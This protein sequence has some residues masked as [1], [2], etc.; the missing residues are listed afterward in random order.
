MW[1][2]SYCYSQSKYELL[3]TGSQVILKHFVSLRHK[4]WCRCPY[5]P[6]PNWIIC[7]FASSL[8]SR[9]PVGHIISP[10]LTNFQALPAKAPNFKYYA[11]P[12]FALYFCLFTQETPFKSSL[13]MW[14]ITQK[15]QIQSLIFRCDQ[16]NS[17]S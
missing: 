17:R 10:F 2:K 4:F 6:G 3:G 12:L 11:A 1:Q 16:G 7:G 15:V 13:F 8:R 9:L 5:V 14:Y